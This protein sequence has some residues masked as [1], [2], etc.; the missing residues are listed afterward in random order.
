MAPPLPPHALP[1]VA[2]HDLLGVA[3]PGVEHALDVA[4]EGGAFAGL[5]GEVDGEAADLLQRRPALHGQFDAAIALN[6]SKGALADPPMGE[7]STSASA[8]YGH[9]TRTPPSLSMPVP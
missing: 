7:P 1:P 8:D 6:V 5:R 9:H 2:R 3:C 4:L